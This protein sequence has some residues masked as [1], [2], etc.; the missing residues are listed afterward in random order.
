MDHL[1]QDSGLVTPPTLSIFHW[2]RSFW[3][4]QV[5]SYNGILCFSGQ[6]EWC[7]PER[8]GSS[9]GLDQVILGQSFRSGPGSRQK[10]LVRSSGVRGHCLPLFSRSYHF[11]HDLSVRPSFFLS[12]ISLSLCLSPPLSLSLSHS[13]CLSVSLSLSLSVCQSVSL[14]LS[15][16][17]SVCLSGP[18]Q[19]T[20][21][22]LSTYLTY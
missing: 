20:H 18:R 13:V 2:F 22:T 4:M 16:C 3:L 14:S 15:I 12:F 11:A 21:L 19:V 6:G 8:S 7:A 5:R 1:F 10:S 9:F 17:L